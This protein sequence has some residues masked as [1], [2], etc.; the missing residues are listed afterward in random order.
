MSEYVS[1]KCFIIN[2]TGSIDIK[3]YNLLVLLFLAKIYHIDFRIRWEIKQNDLCKLQFHDIFTDSI[4]KGKIINEFVREK[5]KTYYFNNHM[6]LKQLML[7]TIP[8]NQINKDDNTYNKIPV[9][10]YDYYVMNQYDTLIPD[11]LYWIVSKTSYLDEIRKIQKDLTLHANI[12]GFYNLYQHK[13]KGKYVIGVFISNKDR[14]LDNYLTKMR[15]TVEE[16]T[17]DTDVLYY[18][19]FDEMIFDKREITSSQS[20]FKDEF[21]DQVIYFNHMQ[22]NGNLYSMMNL[23]C[24]QDADMLIT[25]EYD[26]KNPSIIRM[27]TLMKNQTVKC[28]QKKQ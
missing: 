26:I 18:I 16:L 8:T 10:I 13:R 12:Q 2:L 14:S 11:V 9:V 7:S 20:Y 24:F 23:L 3:I 21:L 4:F 1:F 27:F 6:S 5:D 25:S 19:G 22:G 28:L 17:S 15:D